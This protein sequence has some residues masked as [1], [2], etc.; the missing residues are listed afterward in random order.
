MPPGLKISE[1]SSSEM[2]PKQPVRYSCIIIE[3]GFCLFFSSISSGCLC[4]RMS[5]NAVKWIELRHYNNCFFSLRFLAVSL[6]FRGPYL[7]T[8][9]RECVRSILYVSLLHRK[10]TNGQVTQRLKMIYMRLVQSVTNPNVH[11]QHTHT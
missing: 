6:G 7:S 8:K 2:H 11:T 3:F 1:W 4:A 5:S 10:A 9:Q